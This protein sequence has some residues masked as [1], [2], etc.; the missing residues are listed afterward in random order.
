MN[1]LSK[2]VGVLCATTSMAHILYAGFNEDA[3]P[4]KLGT[5]AKTYL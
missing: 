1:F 3:S 2:A 4:V 5:G